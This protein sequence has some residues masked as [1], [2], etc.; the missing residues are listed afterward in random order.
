MQKNQTATNNHN[1]N[2]KKVTGFSGKIFKMENH[3]EKFGNK[4]WSIQFD[5]PN[6]KVNKLNRIVMEEC[7]TFLPQLKQ[8]VASGEMDALVLLSGKAD[9]FI[10]GADISQFTHLK[11]KKEAFEL[12]RQA[13][14]VLDK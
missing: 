13:Q 5:M 6:E 2:S 11:T 1:S 12:I 14:L 8:L 7:Q 10:A 9:N 4:I 3:S